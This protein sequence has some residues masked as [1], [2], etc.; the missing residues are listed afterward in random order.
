MELL[1]KFYKTVEEKPDLTRAEDIVFG[2][3]SDLTDRSGLQNAFEGCDEEIQEE[4]IQKWV[5]IV[6][7]KLGT[8]GRVI[9]LEK[10]GEILVDKVSDDMYSEIKKAIALYGN[11][12]ISFKGIK[13]LQTTVAKNTF[14]KLHK[15]FGNRNYNTIVTLEDTTKNHIL[16]INMGIVD[17]IKDE[18]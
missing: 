4:I 2:I 18:E 7:A 11:V 3:L 6:E 10:Y 15:E 17:A 13:A 8:P 9:K 5:G 12:R 1:N 16:I 14:G